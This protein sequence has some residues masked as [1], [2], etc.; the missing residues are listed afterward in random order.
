MVMISLNANIAKQKHPALTIKR[1]NEWIFV[2]QI[3][4]CMHFSQ[5]KIDWLIDAKT[6]FN[7]VF[8]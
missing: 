3:N 1:M 5:P 6:K 8:H 2:V 7:Y 4:K